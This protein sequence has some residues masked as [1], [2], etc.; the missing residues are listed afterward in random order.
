M[1]RHLVLATFAAAVMTLVIAT[2]EARS[3]D[4]A[5][6][7]STCAVP[8]ANAPH[9]SVFWGCW[10]FFSSGP[11]RAV[12]RDTAGNFSLCGKCGPSGEP[13]PIGCS[14]ISSQ[15]LAIGFWCS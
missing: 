8:A 9:G 3:S 12:Y 15:T 11:C 10:T 14:A 2:R 1:K 6:D 13:N 4:P 5:T 7:G